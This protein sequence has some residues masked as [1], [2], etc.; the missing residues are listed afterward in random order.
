MIEKRRRLQNKMRN[1]MRIFKRQRGVFLVEFAFV[2]P[3][4]L[5][6]ILSGFELARY[7]RVHQ[8]TN[9][10]AYEL[11]RGMILCI[12]PFTAGAEYAPAQ[13]ERT[14]ECFNAYLDSYG[15]MANGFLNG[16]PVLLN[17]RIVDNNNAQVYDGGI[18]TRGRGTFTN[19]H[20][21]TFNA[22]NPNA[23]HETGFSS[24]TSMLKDGELRGKTPRNLSAAEINGIINASPLG[25]GG[26][27]VFTQVVVPHNNLVE[28]LLNFRILDAGN[29]V[30]VNQVS[31]TA[32]VY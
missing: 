24:I 11:A 31:G 28:Q 5:F 32:L 21:P 25:G 12:N 19:E 8:V 23:G 6:L 4:I 1:V 20:R 18:V 9:K 15:N 27:A 29:N 16:S 13:Q 7:I 14:V 22:A 3:I 10:V 17:A 30:S 26:V 2:M